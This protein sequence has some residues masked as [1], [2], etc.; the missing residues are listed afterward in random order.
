MWYF[1]LGI[2]NIKFGKIDIGRYPEAGQKYHVS[3]SSLSK[4]LPTVILF[5]EG[6][7]TIIFKIYC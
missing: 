3:D 1:V 2:D 5:Q 6:K 4:Q 7:A